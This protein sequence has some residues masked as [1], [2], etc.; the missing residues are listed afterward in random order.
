MVT[1]HFSLKRTLFSCR[2]S[3]LDSLEKKNARLF[4]SL[5]LWKP[6]NHCL[7]GNFLTS[8]I[9]SPSLPSGSSPSGRLN[10]DLIGNF[11]PNSA[12]LDQ[13]CT[14]GLQNLCRL[15]CNVFHCQ[16]QDVVWGMGLERVR[17]SDPKMSRN[18]Y[19]QVQA[20]CPCFSVQTE[21]K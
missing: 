15:Y 14:C 17:M 18:L 7:L 3:D 10:A 5:H 1:T 9:N 11:T 4:S 8:C 2:A 19:L 6:W 12:F 21:G 13:I 20:F 16:N